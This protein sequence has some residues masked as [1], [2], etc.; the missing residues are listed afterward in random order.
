MVWIFLNIFFK[1]EYMNS[2]H[3]SIYSTYK[4]VWILKSL[5]PDNFFCELSLKGAMTN[6]TFFECV[7][8]VR[9]FHTSGQQ[10]THIVDVPHRVH[11]GHSPC[12][13]SR[14]WVLEKLS[15]RNMVSKWIW[16]LFYF[17]V[18][19]I[20]SLKWLMD[21]VVRFLCHCNVILFSYSFSI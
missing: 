10:V 19:C 17:Y 15:F 8:Q 16:N 9:W 21:F 7:R 4:V 18:S 13:F 5:G 1:T 2:E 6:Q 3:L 11:L 12:D 14:V 20:K